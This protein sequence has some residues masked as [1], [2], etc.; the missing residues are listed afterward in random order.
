MTIAE[1]VERIPPAVFEALRLYVEER[2]HPGDGFLMAVLSNDLREAVGRADERSYAS[3]RELIVY[4]HNE[5]PGR[6]WGSKARV[7]E[8]VESGLTVS[9][10]RRGSSRVT[11]DT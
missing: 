11:S 10:S 8:W 2:V 1:C 9:P 3:L 7:V 6:C 4:L 5:V